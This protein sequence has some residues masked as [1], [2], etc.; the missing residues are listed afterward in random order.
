MAG[1]T[2]IEV[3]RTVYETHRE[4]DTPGL[5]DLLADDVEWVTAEGHPYAGPGP[6]RGHQEVVEH[7][8][9]RVNFDW[10]G[11]E[12]EVEQIIDGGDE[13]VV[14]ARYRGTYKA[15]G[16]SIDAPV[17]VIYTVR[18]GKIVRFRQYTDTAQ[19]RAAMGVD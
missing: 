16:R 15:T 3:I 4:R 10:D 19:F 6:W 17:C 12:T 5:L 7:V 11:Y 14:T 13:I 8:V 1:P 2:P 9:D 18:D